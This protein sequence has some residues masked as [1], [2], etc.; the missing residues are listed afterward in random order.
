MLW[1]KHP[2]CA[3][4][5][6]WHRLSH[7]GAAVL[8]HVDLVGGGGKGNAGEDIHHVRF[9][10]CIEVRFRLATDVGVERK[11]RGEVKPLVTGHAVVVLS[12]V[13]VD[14]GADVGAATIDVE[15]A[16]WRTITAGAGNDPYVSAGL[17][18]PPHGRI[19]GSAGGVSV[20]PIASRGGVTAGSSVWRVWL[21]TSSSLSLSSVSRGSWGSTAR[22]G[23]PV[24]GNAG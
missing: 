22:F 24:G 19:G 3:Q 14:T 15:A 5:R 4:A 21:S 2:T 10:M 20:G 12:A 11:G 9:G 6:C 16:V 8:V 1:R 18:G 17:E 23:C 13:E 7:S